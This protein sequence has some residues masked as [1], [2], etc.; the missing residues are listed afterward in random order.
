MGLLTFF[1]QFKVHLWI[2]RY[3]SSAILCFPD[4]DRPR[5]TFINKA[6]RHLVFKPGSVF[7][8]QQGIE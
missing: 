1:G 7:L 8:M 6:L 5:I 3:L 2:E 4:P